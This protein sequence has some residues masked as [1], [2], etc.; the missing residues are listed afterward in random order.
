MA[1][2]L[3][4]CAL[5]DAHASLARSVLDPCGSSLAASCCSAHS[6]TSVLN[7]RSNDASQ[8]IISFHFSFK[9]SIQ[10]LL[11]GSQ[12]FAL[13]S[14]LN[15]C[16][17]LIRSLNWRTTLTLLKSQL[18]W[19]KW[20]R[21]TE[22]S[23]EQGSEKINR[24]LIWLQ[25]WWRQM[26]GYRKKKKEIRVTGEE[27]RRKGSVWKLPYIHWRVIKLW[28]SNYTLKRKYRVLHSSLLIKIRPQ[29]L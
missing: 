7:Q 17:S 15:F 22:S 29:I 21:S 27:E 28:N 6:R 10:I 11:E 19:L 1:H 9:P 20:W 16:F 26:W 3:D 4:P 24:C 8:W 12:I 18:Q 25:W 2:A 13:K 5:K 14:Q 23:I